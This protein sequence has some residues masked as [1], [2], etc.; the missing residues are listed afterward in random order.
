M[1]WPSPHRGQ[2][3]DPTA[4]HDDDLLLSAIGR[5]MPP[6]AGEPVVDLLSAWR[7]EIV[8]TAARSLACD[9]RPAARQGTARRALRQL[10]LAATAVVV[11]AGLAAAFNATPE[12][13]LWPV[14]TAFFPEQANVRLARE[15]IHDARQAAAEGR[16]GD[17]RRHLEEASR[18]VDRLGSGPRIEQLRSE[19]DALRTAL[20]GA[21]PPVSGIAPPAADTEPPVPAPSGTA[22]PGPV[23]A[24]PAPA[25][26]DPAPPAGPL[27]P[28]PVPSSPV[29]ASPAPATPVAPGPA[30]PAPTTGPRPVPRPGTAH[31]SPPGTA[32]RP[33]TAARP[34][35]GRERTGRGR[36]PGPPP[37]Q[38]AAPAVPPPPADPDPDPDP[39]PG[40][41]TAPGR[42]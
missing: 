6:P 13:P 29:P 3:A 30:R 41:A 36:L 40:Q 10:V 7:A 11:T 27:L 12:S 18:L 8:R 26:A 15:A 1:R 24:S 4:V 2:P 23:P 25:P 17:S 16:Y 19:I 21:E 9:A 34:G 35:P 32:A 14:T 37:V 38:R 22:R 28:S 39:D 5:D 42:E 20:P 31:A 33:D